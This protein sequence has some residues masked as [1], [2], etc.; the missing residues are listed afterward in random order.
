MLYGYDICPKC[1]DKLIKRNNKK[2]KTVLS[3]MEKNVK[4]MEIG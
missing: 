4:G 1:K 2:M 3:F